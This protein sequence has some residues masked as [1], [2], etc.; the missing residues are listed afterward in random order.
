MYSSLLSLGVILAGRMWNFIYVIYKNKPLF[1]NPELQLH[2]L[3]LHVT[4]MIIQ[5]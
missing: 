2:L 5:L 4:L 1:T 3:T